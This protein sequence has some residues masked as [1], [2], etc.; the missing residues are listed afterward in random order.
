MPN[1]AVTK[2]TNLQSLNRQVASLLL[3]LKP[4]L[5]THVA[6]LTNEFYISIHSYTHTQGQH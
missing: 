3:T 2:Q 4:L 6:K 1:T 5:L